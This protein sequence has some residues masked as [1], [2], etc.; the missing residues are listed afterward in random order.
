MKISSTDYAISSTDYAI[1]AWQVEM[2]IL[3]QK[4]IEELREKYCSSKADRTIAEQKFSRIMAEIEHVYRK[5]YDTAS[6][7]P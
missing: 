4:K 5:G 6:Q 2:Q 7:E 3:C 1:L